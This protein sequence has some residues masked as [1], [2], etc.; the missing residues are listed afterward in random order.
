[1]DG[2]CGIEPR[3]GGHETMTFPD[4]DNSPVD[5]GDHHTVSCERM[6]AAS[7]VERLLPGPACPR[8]PPVEQRQLADVAALM[9]QAIDRFS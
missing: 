9:K 1:V 7:R 8:H 6:I 2:R 4:F 5:G 3:H